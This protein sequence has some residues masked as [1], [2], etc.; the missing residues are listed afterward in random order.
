MYID[1][2]HDVALSLMLLK[3]KTIA[4]HKVISITKTLNTR[5]RLLIYTEHMFVC[6]KYK[7]K[8]IEYDAPLK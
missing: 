3:R 2:G 1:T 8:S 5:G 6:T 4:D 7:K